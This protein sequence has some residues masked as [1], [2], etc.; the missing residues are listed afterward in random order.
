MGERPAILSR[1]YA[2]TRPDDGVVVVRDADGI[3]A[4]LVAQRRRAADAGARSCPACSVLVSPDRYL[5]GRLAEQQLGATVHVLDDGFQ[6]LQ[7][8]R[9][10]DLVIV[11]R[12]DVAPTRYAARRAACA[13]RSTRASPPMRCSPPTTRC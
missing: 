13:S 5:A 8:D 9:D 11:G 10:I 2:R 6:H 7:L 12:E 3:R 1:G 4:D